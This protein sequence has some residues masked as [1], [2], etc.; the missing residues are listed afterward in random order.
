MDAEIGIEK[1]DHAHLDTQ[2]HAN[3][4]NLCVSNY[5][6]GNYNGI[7]VALAV[8]YDDEMISSAEIYGNIDD[9]MGVFSWN[10]SGQ[11][12]P[13]LSVT[14][15]SG[16]EFN[17]SL[18]SGY[19]L[20][21]YCSGEMNDY[22]DVI[23]GSA[24]SNPIDYW[25][26]CNDL[27]GSYYTPSVSG[28]TITSINQSMYVYIDTGYA[29]MDTLVVLIDFSSNSDYYTGNSIIVPTAQSL[30][31]YYKNGSSFFTLTSQT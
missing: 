8:L 14:L 19:A 27:H 26:S 2:T 9:S 15:R 20:R 10:M 25:S 30:T 5:I 28:Q 29:Y 22:Y 21:A 18:S 6:G 4:G 11:Y 13:A 17:S 16:Y 24:P 1:H 3:S 31:A 12:Q 7:A 23:G